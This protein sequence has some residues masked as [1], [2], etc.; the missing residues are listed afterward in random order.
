MEQQ[1]K[2]ATNVAQEIASS[3]RGAVIWATSL[4]SVLYSWIAFRTD[5]MLFIYVHLYFA[6][7]VAANLILAKRGYDYI[8]R[9]IFLI[10]ALTVVFMYADSLPHSS[11]THMFFLLGV[12][13]PVFVRPLQSWRTAIIP[14]VLPIC[15]WIICLIEGPGLIFP[16][17]PSP[18]AFS[19]FFALAS[20]VGVLG[21]FFFSAQRRFLLLYAEVERQGVELARQSQMA[22]IGKIAGEVAHDI[23]NPLTLI[24]GKAERIQRRTR[25]QT[26]VDEQID[27][28]AQRVIQTVHR[29]A[30]S[31]S[32]LRNSATINEFTR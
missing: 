27:A 2:S 8:S 17:A 14:T 7:S 5:N 29:I 6:V 15:I 12:I 28:D 13:F 18:E 26:V 22:A 16:M 31:V 3:N 25:S 24:L 30:Q 23:N 32:K 19:P 11:L 20:L 9:Y 21:A 1:T 10:A 4:V